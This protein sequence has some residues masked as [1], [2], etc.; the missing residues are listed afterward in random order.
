MKTKILLLLLL[1]YSLKPYAMNNDEIKFFPI[2]HAS[3][4]IQYGDVIIMVDPVGDIKNYNEFPNPQLIVITHSH[5]DHFN[6]D[7]VGKIKNDK[8]VIIAPKTV[9]DMLGY[10]ITLGNG[11]IFTFLNIK[12]EAVPAYNITP[13]RMMFHPK[14]IGN[15][16][17]LT[18]G[19]KRIYISGDTE[20]IQEIK[21]LK[22]IDY[23][24][25]C[26]NIPFTMTVEQAASAVL[27]FKP[28][29]VYPYHYRV[30]DGF[31][32]IKK[33]KELVSENPEIDVVFLK[34][35]E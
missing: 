33:F 34:W 29:H 30:K 8:T 2:N 3:F 35:Y 23:A 21:E 19:D 31:S 1:L 15:G 28:K 14:G 13:E 11:G 22:N 4:V 32:N 26:M 12:I 9:T 6:N 27:E 18:L 17:I 16:Y 25:V 5:G 24:F 20:D 10:G 7:L